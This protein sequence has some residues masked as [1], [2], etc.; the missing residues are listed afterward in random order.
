MISDMWLLFVIES[1]NTTN[2]DWFFILCITVG[3]S[4]ILLIAV[5]IVYDISRVIYHYAKSLYLLIFKAIKSL[6]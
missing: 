4:V 1:L 5:H 3:F 6:K 2:L